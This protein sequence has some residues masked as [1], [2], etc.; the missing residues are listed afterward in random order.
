MKKFRSLISL[1]LT[2]MILTATTACNSTT[3]TTGNKQPENSTTTDSANQDKGAALKVGIV[4]TTS[5][6]GDKSFNDSAIAGLEKATAELGIE[7]K[8]VQPKEASEIEKAIENLANAGYELIFTVGFNSASA[9]SN[10]A[11][12]Y[13]D[14][15]FVIIDH[16]FKDDFKDNL[17]SLIFK[18][19]EGSFLA[20]VLAAGQS[21][22]N[23]VGFVGGMESPLIQKFEV[24][25]EAGVKAANPDAEVLIQYVSSDASGF[26]NPSRAKEITLN[27]ISKNADVIYHAAGGSG[28]GMLDA[29]NEKGILAIGVDSNQNWV[30]PGTVIASMLKRVDH[31]VFDVVKAQIDGTLVMGDAQIYGL[32][33]NGVS[34]TDLTELMA[35][36]TDGIS[37]DDQQKIKNLKATI[38]DDTKAKI[39]AFKTQIIEGELE[40]PS[41]RP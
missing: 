38:T 35:E 40:V 3:T 1:A 25:F 20:G 5:G 32:D 14:T 39:E 2:F 41:V 15:K 19:E 31:A 9:L 4:L 22:S 6:K 17:K 16:N 24:G 12:S 36:E 27:M 10:V 11:P 30:K 18:E 28:Q 21:T 29:A 33:S 34:L 37:A 13:P 7:Y 26:N 23:V 8:E